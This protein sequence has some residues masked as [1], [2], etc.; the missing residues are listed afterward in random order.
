MGGTAEGIINRAAQN[1]SF[2]V[3]LV[4]FIFAF[5]R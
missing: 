3:L 1:V 2:E 5:I 4:G